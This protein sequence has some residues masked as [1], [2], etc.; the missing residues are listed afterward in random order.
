M[1]GALRKLQRF[2][3]PE[4]ERT[5]ILTLDHGASDGIIPGID[6]IPELLDSLAQTPV[7]GVV[8]NK[9]MARAYT[10]R[11]E[12]EVNLVIQ[13]SGGTK[14]GLPTYNKSLVCSVPEALR[15]GAD[16]VAVHVNIGND[17]EDRMLSDFGM[18]TDEA[19]QMGL[20]VMAVIYARGGQIVN[21]T[22]PALIGHSIRVG[23][24]LGADLVCV[25]YSSDKQSFT[26]AVSTC[27]V[28]VLV[29]GGPLQSDYQTF[30]TQMAEALSCGAAGLS[31]GRNIFQHPTPPEA[32]KALLTLVHEPI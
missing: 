31:I 3:H 20:P 19:H 2:F 8:L 22:D 18:V 12:P 17:L 30:L 29:T 13:L 14:H 1:F 26:H 23:G 5:L 24:E 10:S 27:P 28:P 15:A 4:S 32:L 16:A 21:E 9:G 25:P 6:A 7:Q 11:I